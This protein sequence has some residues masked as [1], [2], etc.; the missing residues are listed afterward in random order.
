MNNNNP[1]VNKKINIFPM[2]ILNYVLGFIGACIAIYLLIINF[3]GPYRVIGI[4]VLIIILLTSYLIYNSFRLKK[5]S[6]TYI[7]LENKLI[8]ADD[9][10]NTLSII[11]NKKE[12]E[13]DYLKQQNSALNGQVQLVYYIAFQDNKPEPKVVEQ[14]L[15]IENKGGID[16]EQ[17]YEDSKNIR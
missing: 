16:N 5:M 15:G 17:K 3:N 4:L 14:A 1:E 6:D 11:I 9:N 7:S 13:I 8:F 2:S 12:K 10:R